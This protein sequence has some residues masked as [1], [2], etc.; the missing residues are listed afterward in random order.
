MS[1]LLPYSLILNL[2]H[3]N[4]NTCCFPYHREYVVLGIGT[5]MCQGICP[6][7]LLLVLVIITIN[8]ANNCTCKLLNLFGLIGYSTS[9]KGKR[10]QSFKITFQQ[11]TY[12]KAK[13]IAAAAIRL[14]G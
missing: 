6:D 14:G 5:V 12:K 4:Y 13:Y 7:N 2:I 1:V 9:A 8:S 10:L 11:A 3:I